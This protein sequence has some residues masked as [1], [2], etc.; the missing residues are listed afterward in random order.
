M[1]SLYF[2]IH[3]ANTFPY[4]LMAIGSEPTDIP[5]IGLPSPPIDPTDQTI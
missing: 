1:N 2:S 4:A 3:V 5:T